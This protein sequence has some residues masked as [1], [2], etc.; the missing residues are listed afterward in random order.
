MALAQ[1]CGREARFRGP[2]LAAPVMCDGASMAM[3]LVLPWPILLDE[4]M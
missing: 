3:F 4:T 1:T 2:G